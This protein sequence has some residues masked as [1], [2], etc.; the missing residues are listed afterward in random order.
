[1]SIDFIG[2]FLLQF[3]FQYYILYYDEKDR[4][5]DDFLAINI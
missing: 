1:M 5:L 2:R 3:N 4:F